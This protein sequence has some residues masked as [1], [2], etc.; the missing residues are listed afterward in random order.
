MSHE[1]NFKLYLD[2]SNIHINNNSVGR[3]IRKIVTSK[4][5]T[6]HSSI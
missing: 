3:E 1:E 6:L 5:E 2:D 4:K